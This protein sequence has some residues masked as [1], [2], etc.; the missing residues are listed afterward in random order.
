MLR[1]GWLNSQCEVPVREQDAAVKK[2]EVYL[3]VLTHHWA[4]KQL[5]NDMHIT[6]LCFFINFLLN[7]T[8]PQSNT[9][10]HL[11]S[12]SMTM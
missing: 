9:T 8:I 10:N 6:R 12:G 4:G 5:K 11:G 7:K 1:A 3:S 2:R